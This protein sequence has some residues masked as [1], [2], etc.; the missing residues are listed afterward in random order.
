M[1]LCREL[2]NLAATP[3]CF[4]ADA[5]DL[6]DYSKASVEDRKLIGYHCWMLEEAG[7]L[8]SCAGLFLRDTQDCCI[9]GKDQDSDDRCAV[10]NLTMKGHDLLDSLGSD[11][12]FTKA[13]ECIDEMLGGYAPVAEWQRLVRSFQLG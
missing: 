8:D 9:Y 1:A 4:S 12:E 2:L 7:Y 13:K 10:W 6:E 3:G 11:E 5:F